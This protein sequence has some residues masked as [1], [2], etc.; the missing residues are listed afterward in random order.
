MLTHFQFCILTNPL[1]QLSIFFWKTKISRICFADEKR[2]RKHQNSWKC[3][4]FDCFENA[5]WTQTSFF[6]FMKR[7]FRSWIFIAIRFDGDFHFACGI[8]NFSCYFQKSFDFRFWFRI[9]FCL[10]SKNSFLICDCHHNF[11]ICNFDGF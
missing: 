3:R 10:M 4:R 9:C 5:H 8:L 11:Y 1:L 7:H 2:G 6:E